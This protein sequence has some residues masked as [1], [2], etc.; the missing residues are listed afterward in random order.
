MV[1]LLKLDMIQNL[2]EDVILLHIMQT[3]KYNVRLMEK[4]H[5]STEKCVKVHLEEI[6][7]VVDEVDHH[8]L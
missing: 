7:K 2:L 1:V 4:L 5:E 8:V 6:L 3:L